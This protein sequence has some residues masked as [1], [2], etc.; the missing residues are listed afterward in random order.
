MTAEPTARRRVDLQLWLLL[1]LAAGVRF[2]GLRFGLRHTYARPDELPVCGIAKDFLSGDLNPHFWA[3]PTL[4]MYIVAVVDYVYYLFGR[5]AG[6]FHSLEHFRSTWGE[7]WVPFFLSGR[8]VSATAGTATVAVVYRIGER[9]FDR[10][11][12][13]IAGLFLALAFLHV[14]DSH[15]GVTDV[16]MTFLVTWSS[17][18]LAHGALTNRRAAF[19]VAGVLAGAAAS[20]KYNGVLMLVPLVAAVFVAWSVDAKGRSIEALWRL[21]IFAVLFVTGFVA[22]SPFS[23]IDPQPFIRGFLAESHHIPTPHAQ[24]L[25]PGGVY[26]VVFSLRYGVGIPL[27]VAAVAGGLWLVRLDRRKAVLLGSFP[28]AYYAVLIPT[29]TVFVRYA[30]PLVPFLCVSAAFMTSAAARF[31]SQRYRR[32][33]A[34]VTWAIALV[35]IA[36]SAY[37]V[38]QID[39]MFA[40]SDSRLMLADWIRANVKPGSSIHLAGNIVVQPIVDYGPRQTLRY[41]RHRGGWRFAEGRPPRTTPVEGIPD[42]LVIPDSGIPIWSGSAPELKQLAAAQYDVVHVLNAMDITRNLFDQQ[43]AFFYPYAGFH[44]VRRGGPNYIVYARKAG[45]R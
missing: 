8:I 25:G 40:T 12:G 38:A 22:G 13:A 21:A 23:V 16:A 41:W 17:L 1:A 39:R 34:A 14:R 31:L 45:A 7:Y 3:Y 20:T 30:I 36:P 15:F 18:F 19:A 32:P 44:S 29:R 5:M 4:F 24:D 37:S 42:W 6:W 43:D 28:L 35:I 9:L 11:T 10:R 33:A 2:Y 26:H 27:L